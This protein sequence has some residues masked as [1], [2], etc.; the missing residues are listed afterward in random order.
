MLRD[1]T[2][3]NEQEKYKHNKREKVKLCD[4]NRHKTLCFVS[5]QVLFYQQILSTDLI[6][7]Q[8]L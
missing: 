6:P 5:K 1:Q 8:T 2:R 4:C 3:G 7:K